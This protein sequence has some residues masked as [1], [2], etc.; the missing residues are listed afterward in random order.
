MQKNSICVSSVLLSIKLFIYLFLFVSFPWNPLNQCGELLLYFHVLLQRLGRPRN[1]LSTFISTFSSLLL[2]TSNTFISSNPAPPA[3]CPSSPASN[4][5]PSDFPQ[6]RV[7]STPPYLHLK[8]ELVRVHLQPP[9]HPES[10]SSIVRISQW[11]HVKS[12]GSY[13]CLVSLMNYE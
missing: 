12:G 6:L 7:W 2:L 9:S 1:L 3:C 11:G 8:G 5:S 4:S 13:S 10:S